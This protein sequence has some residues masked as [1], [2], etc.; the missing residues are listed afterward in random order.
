MES[1]LL[2]IERQ[3]LSESTIVLINPLSTPVEILATEPKDVLLGSLHDRIVPP[4]G[5]LALNGGL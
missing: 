1:G 4:Y 2:R 5:C 3:Y